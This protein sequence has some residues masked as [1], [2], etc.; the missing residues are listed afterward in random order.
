MDQCGFMESSMKV[1]LQGTENSVLR[2]L[3]NRERWNLLVYFRKVAC[4]GYQY[5]LKITCSYAK[6]LTKLNRN[7]KSKIK[8]HQNKTNS[9]VEK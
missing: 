6:L 8:Y 3:E 1:H 5:L 9:V 2:F 4:I 7:F